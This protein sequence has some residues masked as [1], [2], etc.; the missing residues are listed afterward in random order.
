[1]PQLT[2]YNNLQ[3]IVHPADQEV[4]IRVTLVE[5]DHFENFEDI[6]T[7]KVPNEP[8]LNNKTSD[9]KNNHE[10]IIDEQILFVQSEATFEFSA[11]QSEAKFLYIKVKS[12]KVKYKT[13]R[14]L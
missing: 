11:V 14:K 12:K 8:G 13:L 9:N 6:S 1:M 2:S 4:E 7:P 5:K 3:I 10:T